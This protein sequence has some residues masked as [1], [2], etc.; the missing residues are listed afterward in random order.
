MTPLS[1]TLTTFVVRGF[2]P[3]GLR[4]GPNPLNAVCLK[5]LDDRAGAAAQP[6]GDKSPRHNRSP[7][8]QKYQS[9]KELRLAEGWVK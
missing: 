9:S 5:K 2:I 7:Y 1:A 8:R 6:I 4:S 3:D